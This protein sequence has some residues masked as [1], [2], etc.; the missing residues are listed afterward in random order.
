MQGPTEWLLGIRAKDAILTPSPCLAAPSGTFPARFLWLPPGDTWTSPAS[1]LGKVRRAHRTVSDGETLPQAPDSGTAR[2]N[3]PRRAILQWMRQTS[4]SLQLPP[5]GWLLTKCT[6]M[7]LV[8]LWQDPRGGPVS[9]PSLYQASEH[10]CLSNGSFRGAVPQFLQPP[11]PPGN[12]SRSPG[13][14]GPGGLLLG[15]TRL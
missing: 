15:P 13:S 6:P 10:C 3:R 2:G 8:T 11:L 9:V 7:L 4:S 12:V 1:C 5:E 14:G